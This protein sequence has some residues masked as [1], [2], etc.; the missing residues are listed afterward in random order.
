[1]L[2]FSD[3][4]AIGQVSDC[5]GKLRQRIHDLAVLGQSEAVGMNKRLAV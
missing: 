5:T 1:M 4:A 2:A 3:S